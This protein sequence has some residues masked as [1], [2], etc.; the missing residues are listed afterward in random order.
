M[1]VCVVVHLTHPLSIIGKLWPS[2]MYCVLTLS[3]PYHAQGAVIA[4]EDTAVLG[5]ILLHILS[6]LQVPSLL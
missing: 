4:V 1:L 3:Q 2:G 5:M 6:F